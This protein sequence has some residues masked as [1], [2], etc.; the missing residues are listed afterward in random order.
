MEIL[1]SEHTNTKLLKNSKYNRLGL[2]YK[3]QK[4]T[5]NETDEQ[6]H[7]DV[8]IKTYIMNSNIRNIE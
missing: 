2:I 6:S 4:T 7:M 5:Q 1:L 8:C 3:K